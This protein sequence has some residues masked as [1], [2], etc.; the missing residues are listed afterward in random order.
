M[1]VKK[2]RDRNVGSVCIWARMV[3]LFPGAQL[4]T[5][6]IKRYIQL[7]LVKG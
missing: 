1:K 7:Q 2:E 5:D 6:H 4:Q 3:N